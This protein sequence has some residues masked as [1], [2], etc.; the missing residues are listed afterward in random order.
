MQPS[1]NEVRQISHPGSTKWTNPTD[2]VVKFKLH[3]GPPAVRGEGKDHVVLDPGFI[4][5]EMTAGES[6]LLP[7]VYDDAIQH[8]DSHGIIM[9]GLAPH[10]V[11]NDVSHE[12][13]PTLDPLEQQRLEAGR[14][15]QQAVLDKEAADTAVVVAQSKKNEAERKQKAEA[16]SR[17]PTPSTA[18][19]QK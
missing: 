7:S 11:K 13:H 2:R 10:L 12:M 8:Y 3:K 5:V 18:P 1:A 4:L 19:A 14:Q 17:K 6:V 9:S 15:A 16:D